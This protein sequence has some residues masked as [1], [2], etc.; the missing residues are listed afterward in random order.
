MLWQEGFVVDVVDHGGTGSGLGVYRKGVTEG[1]T[2]NNRAIKCNTKQDAA[3]RGARGDLTR[4]EVVPVQG[5]NIRENIP[6]V[7]RFRTD[8]PEGEHNK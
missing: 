2:I 4:Y 5:E 6:G 1:N 7:S 3:I 8:E